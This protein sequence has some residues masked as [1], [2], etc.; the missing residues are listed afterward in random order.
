MDAWQV[1]I[2]RHN[3]VQANTTTAV[4][5]NTGL[6]ENVDVFL[7]TWAGGVDPLGA[8]S[9]L[10]LGRIVDTLPTGADLLASHEKVI[11]IRDLG[12]GWVH[13]GVE[14][15]GRLGELVEDVE[16]GLVLLA[17]EGA[18]GL[19]LWS[20]HVLIVAD[21]AELLGAFLAEELLAFGKGQ[22]DLPAIL[23]KKELVGRVDGADQGNLLGAAVLDVAE[24]ME[25]NAFENLLRVC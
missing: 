6:P 8:N 20:A 17:D 9:R 24:N 16:V 25:E 18:E 19:L 3:T 21:V 23:G 11:G 4:S 7:D 15:T 22:A 5:R 2:P 12:V 10:Q 1:Q 13:L 14:G